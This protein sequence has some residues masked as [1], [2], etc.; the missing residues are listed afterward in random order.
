MEI[1]FEER[2]SNRW[3][4]LVCLLVFVLLLSGCGAR[5][6]RVYRV[7]VLFDQLQSGTG[8]GITVPEALLAQADNV[9][10]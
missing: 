7:G 2:A 3:R 8:T 5:K 9:I 4:L 6:P 10:R 1:M